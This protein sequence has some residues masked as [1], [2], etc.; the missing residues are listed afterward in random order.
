MEKI[1][2]IEDFTSISQDKIAMLLIDKARATSNIH[3]WYLDE[4]FKKLR[5]QWSSLPG[6]RYAHHTLAQFKERFRVFLL[7]ESK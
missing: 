2:H 5:Q 4:A 1:L 6:G 7:E 3:S